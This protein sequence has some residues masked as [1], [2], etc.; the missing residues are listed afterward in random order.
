VLLAPLPALLGNIVYMLPGDTRAWIDPTPG[1]LALGGGLI[2]W[3]LFRKGLLDLTPVARTSLVEF[4]HDGIV[5][6]DQQLRVTDA[7]PVGQQVLRCRPGQ[8]LP[9][10]Y[11]DWIGTDTK[12]VIT[13]GRRD[14]AP[15]RYVEWSTQPVADAG[16]A[17]V[18]R[19]VTERH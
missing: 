11:R 16:T 12:R 7:N 13:L 18:L 1:G 6:V 19:D 8:P 15:E 9:A 10:P 5:V 17:I 2:A 3:G 4:L 14:G